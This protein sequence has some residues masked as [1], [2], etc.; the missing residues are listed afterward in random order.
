MPRAGVTIQ[1]E[2][3][4]ADVG[5]EKMVWTPQ[6]QAEF[7][8]DHLGPVLHKEQPGVKIIGFD[9]NKDHVQTWAKG[10]YA[11]PKAKEYFDGI[12]VHWYGGLN[13]INLDTTHD[14]APEKFILATEAC[15]CPGVIYE[16]E[17]VEWWGRA[18]HLGMDIMQ[19]LLHWCTGWVDWNLILDTTGGP[20][21]L[22][23]RCDANIIADPDKT[24][25]YGTLV[26]Q[27]SYYYMGH[28][29]RYLPAG[30]VRVD[31]SNTVIKKRPVTADDVQNSMPIVFMPCDGTDLQSWTHDDT[32]SLFVAETTWKCVDVSNYGA[33]PRLDTY[34]CA[35][36]SNQ[37]WERRINPACSAADVAAYGVPCSQLVSPATGKCLT[38]VSASGATIGLDPGSTYVVAQAL[39]CKP[40]GEPSQIFDL[41]NGDQGGFPTDFPIRS[42]VEANGD[43]EAQELCMQPYVRLEPKF[44]A[45][46]FEKP[47]GS[48]SVVA[49]NNG[50]E[51]LAFDLYDE[52]LGMGVTDVSMPPHSIQSFALPKPPHGHATAAL[53]GLGGI[54]TTADLAAAP[55]AGSTGALAALVGTVA[56]FALL[57]LGV[58]QAVRVARRPRR[59]HVSAEEHVYV[60]Y[61]EVK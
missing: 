22:G 7:V 29:S 14:L 34:E 13:T 28:F 32:G 41:V 50:D 59:L 2:A 61:A 49:L 36:S 27:A 58:A 16:K 10:L 21:H 19:D 31:M 3:E 11:D 9:H 43:D 47:D 24:Q 52:A 44:D 18:E 33:G 35:H 54:T 45:V 5:W 6:F 57:V 15:N 39:P 42:R 1:N 17:H 46:A 8:R 4:A 25:G 56:V 23:N 55:R 12:G 48:V 51:A 26:M 20:N 37:L 30:S 38:K 60:E 53:V 40:I